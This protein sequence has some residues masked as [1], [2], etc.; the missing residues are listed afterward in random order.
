MTPP[1]GQKLAIELSITLAIL[2]VLFR[3]VFDGRPP[4]PTQR[5]H[6]LERVCTA[7]WDY[8]SA[9]ERMPTRLSELGDLRTF[10]I[11]DAHYSFRMGQNEEGPYMWVSDGTA[12]RLFSRE[13]Q[14]LPVHR[15]E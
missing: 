7:L 12:S 9:N 4:L 6:N 15:L 1:S 10:D 3:Y 11:D 13:C 2:C 8:H 5:S 14:R